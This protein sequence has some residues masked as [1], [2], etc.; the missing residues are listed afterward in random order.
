MYYKTNCMGICIYWRTYKLEVWGAQGGT[1]NYLKYFGLGGY[2]VGNVYLNKNQTLYVVVGGMGQ[3]ANYNY[4]GGYNGGGNGAWGPGNSEAGPQSAYGGGG[5]THIATTNGVLSS[6]VNNR[7]SVLL[8]AGGGGGNGGDFDEGCR[9]SAGGAGGGTEGGNGT[10]SWCNPSTA[11]SGRGGTQYSGGRSN[12]KGSSGFGYGASAQGNT[13]GGAG[14]G[15]GWYGGGS[16]NRHHGGGGGG[17]GYISTVLSNSGM[18]SG[19]HRGNGYA[20][21]SIIN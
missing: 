9:S 6:F 15:G 13:W 11:Y 10:C 12:E 8:V 18:S 3:G 4:A 2:A 21:I 14:G 20:K 19:V 16:S 1:S 5:A 17:S 7:N